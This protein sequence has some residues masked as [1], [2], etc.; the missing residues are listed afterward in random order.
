VCEYLNTQKLIIDQIAAKTQDRTHR[1]RFPPGSLRI[2][3][4]GEG[5]GQDAADPG[6]GERQCSTPSALTALSHA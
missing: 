3:M 2:A 4:G 5:Q 6:N 1:Q